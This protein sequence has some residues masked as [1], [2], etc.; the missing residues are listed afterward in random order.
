MDKNSG[1]VAEAN[2]IIERESVAEEN[3]PVEEPYV[4]IEFDTEEAA[5]KFYEIYARH[6]GFVVRMDQCRRSEVDKRVISRRLSCNKQGYYN[7]RDHSKPSRK[8]RK[9]TREGCN[10][11]MMVKINK[12]GKWVVTRFEKQHTHPLIA[13]DHPSSV[14]IDVK[15]KRI[16]ILTNELAR[17]DRLCNLY[18][19]QI[20]TFLNN[21][22]EQNELLTTKIQVA[23]NNVKE[24]E[25]KAQKDSNGQLTILP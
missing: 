11:M 20:Q 1:D 18:R 13:S 6:K 22:E 10:A 4:G 19:E 25:N 7:I 21:I 16:Q 9:S 24:L 5:K 15:D 14:S 23:V 2:L 12:S 8:L 3:N 17:Q